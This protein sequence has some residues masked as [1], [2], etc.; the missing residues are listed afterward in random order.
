MVAVVLWSS[1]AAMA[2]GLSTVASIGPGRHLVEDFSPQLIR[3]HQQPD[4]SICLGERVT[5]VVEAGDMWSGSNKVDIV[6]VLGTGSIVSSQGG[7]DKICVYD[8]T[9]PDRYSGS[10]IFSGEGNDT[11]I[12]YGGSNNI[13]TSTGSDLIYLNGDIESV[14]TAEDDDHIWGLG[15]ERIT[16]YGGSGNDLVIGSQGNDSLNGGSGDDVILANGGNDSVTELYGSNK[17]YG[18]TGTDTLTGGADYDLCHDF[19]EDTTFAY[20]ETV[21]QPPAPPLPEAG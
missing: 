6:V 4:T 13:D 16:A 1:T 2:A 5:S 12:T 10:E 9:I 19:N 15:A 14:T 7:D 21:I 17:L 18:G 11:V 20:C 3:N 8:A